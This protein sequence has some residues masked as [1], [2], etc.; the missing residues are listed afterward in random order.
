MKKKTKKNILCKK[1][2]VGESPRRFGGKAKKKEYS[3]D[4]TVT[5]RKKN[6]PGGGKEPWLQLHV[7]SKKKKEYT[8][9]N[10]PPPMPSSKGRG[11]KN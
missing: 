7:E 2:N 5:K 1:L 6:Y 9:K 3:A 10:S 8:G 4:R 11:D